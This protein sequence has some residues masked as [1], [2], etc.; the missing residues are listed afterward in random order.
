LADQCQ[1]TNDFSRW[2]FVVFLQ[3]KRD[4]IAAYTKWMTMAQLQTGISTN[5]V[6]SDNGG[7]YVSSA[8]KAFRDDSGTTHQTTVA[9]TPQQNGVTKR[10][11]RVI[12]GMARTMMRHKDVDQDPMVDAI[13][14]EV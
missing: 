10:L 6:Q 7:V 8:V 4:V 12:V 14:T 9:D 13:R 2:T 3:K 11:N 1:S 5:F